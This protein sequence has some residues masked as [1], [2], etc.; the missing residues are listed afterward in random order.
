MV[1]LTAKL[2]T[3]PHATLEAPVRRWLPEYKSRRDRLIDVYDRY[4]DSVSADT[5]KLRNLAFRLRYQVYCLEHPFE[6]PADNPGRL[7]TDEFDDDALHSLLVHRTTGTVAGA[8]RLI[9]PSRNGRWSNLPIRRVCGHPWLRTSNDI[10]PRSRTAEI[11][12]F[13]I[14]K[15]FRR[16]TRNGAGAAGGYGVYSDREHPIPH[17]SLG[18][19]RSIVAMAA[20]SG[21]THLC[22]VMEPALLRLL[23]RLGIHFN[24]LGPRVDYHGRRQPCFSDLDILLSR[25]WA[26]RREVWEVITR[27]GELWPL[28]RELVGSLQSS[29]V[30]AQA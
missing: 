28:N 27:D 4:F 25:T 29:G 24:D 1:R 30:T 19:M 3:A 22:A 10:L 9:L 16:P 5:S 15:A 26:E 7:E 2:V 6:D 13:A 8:V 12:R 21:M 20:D 17:N 18:L 11:S 23:R 14:D